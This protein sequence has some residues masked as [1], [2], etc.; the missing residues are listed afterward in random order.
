MTDPKLVSR[1]LNSAT[2]AFAL[3]A[4]ITTTGCSRSGVVQIQARYRTMDAGS[5]TSAG[6]G[7]ASPLALGHGHPCQPSCCDHGHGASDSESGGST[8]GVGSGQDGADQSGTTPGTATSNPTPAGQPLTRTVDAEFGQEAAA[9]TIEIQ[10]GTSESSFVG[11]DFGHDVVLHV[12]PKGIP[13]ETLA[14]AAI[15]AHYDANILKV[16]AVYSG[17]MIYDGGVKLDTT[18]LTAGRARAI[19]TGKRFTSQDG[20]PDP[21]LITFRFGPVRT[22]ERAVELPIHFE[23]AMKDIQGKDVRLIVR[24]GMVKITPR[25]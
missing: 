21:T 18:T 23:I 5:R 13:I 11:T 19:T 17:S 7:G 16:K 12:N 15:V 14:S 25:K 10:G 6:A 1:F 3:L 8:D 4:A 20:N 22:I 24:P 9:Q 2:V